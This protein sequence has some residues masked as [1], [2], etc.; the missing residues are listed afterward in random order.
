MVIDGCGGLNLELP[1]LDLNSGSTPRLQITTKNRDYGAH[2]SNPET[3]GTQQTPQPQTSGSER[4]GFVKVFY[5]W[6]TWIQ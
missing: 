3:M 2:E 5:L 6:L 1:G 4:S